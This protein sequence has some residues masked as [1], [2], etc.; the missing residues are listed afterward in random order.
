MTEALSDLRTRWGLSNREI[1]RAVHT[2]PSVVRHWRNGVEPNADEVAR[3]DLLNEF[4]ED[5][6]D[7]G[8]AE[9]DAWLGATVV[10]GFTVTRWDLYA[11]GHARLL[12]ANA[13]SE[14]TDEDMLRTIDPDW[15]RTY[16][17][18]F[19]TVQAEDGN[20]SIVGKSYDDI[21][22]QTPEGNR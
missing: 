20:L 16:W 17:T 13:A 9:P 1:A 12:L 21:L 18:S 15:R 6:H 5:V 10:D 11:A 7:Y 14:L 8:I 19:K 2:N 4:L 22:A 3:A